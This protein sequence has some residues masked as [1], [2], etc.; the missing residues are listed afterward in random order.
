MPIIVQRN[1]LDGYEVSVC[2][3]CWTSAERRTSPPWKLTQ[4]PANCTN[5]LAGAASLRK[6]N[7]IYRQFDKANSTGLP[8]HKVFE[9]KQPRSCPLKECQLLEPGCAL[10]LKDE[11]ITMA[12]VAPFN[13][14]MASE[15]A[16]YETKMCISCSNRAETIK[17]DGLVY[18]QRQRILD[19]SQALSRGPAAVV[20]TAA[21]EYRF[22]ANRTVPV[23]AYFKNSETLCPILQC[24]LK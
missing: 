17:N 6:S 10:P 9:N 19:C 2:V 23:S 13:M 5:K 20:Q 7:V 14:S 3:E 22:G 16:G 12:P 4:L 18:R 15:E 1:D 21:F 24:S 11:R 8:I